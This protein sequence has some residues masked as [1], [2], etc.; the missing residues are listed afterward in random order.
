MSW[1]LVQILFQRLQIGPEETPTLS[2]TETE[3]VAVLPELSGVESEIFD[4]TVTV[5]GVV[6]PVRVGSATTIVPI[7]QVV[8]S[9]L[10][11]TL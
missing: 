4:G 9:G 8:G 1:S 3:N 11:L 6:S 5:G 7:G 2:D 10:V